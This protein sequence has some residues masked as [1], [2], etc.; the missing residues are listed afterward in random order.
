MIHSMKTELTLDRTNA[1]ARHRGRGINGKGMFPIPL[2]NIP[3]PFIPLPS[4]SLRR[5]V[6]PALA[7]LLL[8]CALTSSAWGAT[9]D[10]TALLQQGLFE[11]Q[12]N[13]NLDAAIEDYA[14]LARQFDKNRQL[15]ATAV[16]RLGEC[17]RAQGKTPEAAAQYQRILSDFADQQ[18]LATLSRQNLTG[19]GGEPSRATV[20]PSAEAVSNASEASSELEKELALLKARVELATHET[21][22]TLLVEFIGDK[23]LQQCFEVYETVRIRLESAKSG[24]KSE[25]SVSDLEESLKGCDD[26]FKTDFNHWLGSQEFQRRY[27]ESAI[28]QLPKNTSSARQQ[29]KELL[30][31]Q[32]ALAEQDLADTQKMFQVGKATQAEVRAA[33]REGLRLRQ[34]LA[35]LD[36]NKAE[37]LDVSVPAVSEEDKEITRIKQMIQNSPDLINGNA[38]QGSPLG[39]AAEAGQLRVTEFLLDNG[40]DVNAPNDTAGQTPLLVAAHAGRKA[41]VE[42]LLKR[43]ANVNAANNQGQTALHQAVEQGFISVAEVLLAATA[44]P[45]R[46]NEDMQ[47]PLANAARKG[48]R[49]MAALLLAHGADPNIA[50]IVRPGNGRNSISDGR[51]MFGTPLHLAAARGDAE[52]VTLLLTNRA[53]VKAT[54]IYSETPLQVAAAC[55]KADVAELLLAAGSDPNARTDADALTPLHLAVSG[56]YRDVVE[57]LLA[58]DANPNA[59]A[60]INRRDTTPL[61]LAASGGNDDIAL[62][63][64]QRKADPN[65]KDDEGNTA[66]IPAIV[67]TKTAVVKTLLAHGANP[68]VKSSDG[69]PALMMAAGRRNP[70]MTSA[71]LT[72]GADVNVAASGQQRTALQSAAENGNLE[73][74]QILLA[75]HAD[76]NLR[77]ADGNTP[78]HLA[79]MNGKDAVVLLLLDAKADPNLRNNSGATPLDYAKGREKNAS[80]AGGVPGVPGR[81][82]RIGTASG[83]QPQWRSGG[84]PQTNAPVSMADLL[85]RHGA[86]DEL[87]DFTRIRITRQG[88]SQPVQVFYRASTLTNQF[89]LLETVMR[90]YSF[91]SVYI[92]G[93]G[94][95]EA[96]VGLPF[97]D[98]GRV[99]IRRPSQKIGGK[100]QEIK[101]SLLNSSNVVDCAQDVA[102]QFGDVIEIPES[103]H[104]LN[105]ETPNPVWAMEEAF[106]VRTYNMGLPSQSAEVLARVARVAAHRS[107]TLCLQKSVQLV[108]VG[109]TTSFKVNSWKEGF[110]SQ[111]LGKTEARSA[112][113]SSSDLSRVQVTRKTGKS[114]TPAVFTVAVSDPS[115]RN[116]DL[117]LQDGDVIEV[118][119]KR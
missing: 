105:A 32:I 64:L 51:K 72:A 33:E 35:A 118:P 103:V 55:G 1:E 61:M 9:N 58:H 93:A 47:T 99:I 28:S 100:E 117:W 95:R 43:G 98:F 78:L 6:S 54:S 87:P 68:D 109:E 83:A 56:G 85:R 45:N 94:N 7:A 46:Q 53:D 24:A 112:L 73:I 119:E 25:W 29:Q 89:T 91:Q 38:I 88:L 67:N 84:L 65:L 82:R 5:C 39:R 70:E 44:D 18:T 30:A 42:L 31:K 12:A 52:M 71:L 11:E 77:D 63:L 21:N 96:W 86:V 34:Q 3:L 37:L 111:A 19:M 50:R 41:M 107:S 62:L 49:A 115:Q 101:V 59:T 13:R 2:P 40:A 108:V 22:R 20:S 16:F 26:R 60:T 57:R 17:Y 81:L 106:V 114:A 116:D 113:R 15:A 97:P 69:W 80:S 92:P 27:L 75:A 102:V 76:V 79:V 48:S 66:L 10:L 90:F 23:K 4:L 36:S 74:V 110:L 104:A 8:G 14:A